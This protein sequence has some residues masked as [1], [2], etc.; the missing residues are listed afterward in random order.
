[1]TGPMRSTVAERAYRQYRLRIYRFFM[2]RTDSPADAEDLTQRVFADAVEA[3]AGDATPPDSMLAWLYTVAQRR[4]ADEIRQRSR[5][6]Q[7]AQAPNIDTLP[8]VDEYGPNVRAA[9]ETVLAQLSEEQR[10]VVVL[11]L[12]R[13][14]AFA[15]IAEFVGQSEAA[16]KMRFARGITRIRKELEGSNLR[17]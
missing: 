7:T 12:L 6:P 16:C 11:R 3:F 17:P 9:L 15:E 2:R 8:S 10:T 4:M 5:Q 14:L 13:G 1:M